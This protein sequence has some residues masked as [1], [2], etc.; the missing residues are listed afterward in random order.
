M[1]CCVGVV[2]C[3]CCVVP[4]LRCVGICVVLCQCC[5]VRC[6]VGVGVCVGVAIGVAIAVGFVD[7]ECGVFG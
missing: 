5:A 3:G 1:L 7:A 4:V 6:Y 2:L